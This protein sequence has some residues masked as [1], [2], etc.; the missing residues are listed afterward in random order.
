LFVRRRRT[1]CRS[2]TAPAPH[3]PPDCA[4]QEGRGH[5]DVATLRLS[6]GLSSEMAPDC[7]YLSLGFDQSGG[8]SADR[9]STETVPFRNGRAY[10]SNCFAGLEPGVFTM[11]RLRTSLRTVQLLPRLIPLPRHSQ[12]DRALDGHGSWGDLPASVIDPEGSDAVAPLGSHGTRWPGFPV[13]ASGPGNHRSCCPTG[14]ST[15]QLSD[16]SGRRGAETKSGIKR[17]MSAS[18]LRPDCA[19]NPTQ[20]AR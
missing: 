8:W 7:G 12:R 11:G 18:R 3:L 14:V 6:D 2:S 19:T 10:A 15:L 4:A 13:A 20:R 17:H 1:R 9:A 5:L 16:G